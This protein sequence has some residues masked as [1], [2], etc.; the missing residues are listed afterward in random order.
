[1]ND[2]P[3]ALICDFGGVLTSPL[4]EAIAAYGAS[5]GISLGDVGEAMARMAQRD[6]GHPLFE[7]EKGRISEAD[8]VEALEVE[9]GSRLGPFGAYFDNLGRNERMIDYVRE[10]REREIRTALLTNNVR[11]WE[12]RWRAKLPEIED[13]FEVVVDSSSVGMRKPE[14]E[15]YELTVER[16][17]GGLLP[18]EC[19][20]VDD[21]DVN[22]ET[23]RRLGMRAVLFDDTERALAEIER[24]FG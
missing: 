17:G 23:A 19:V 10:L 4:V 6:G 3:R 24:A 8:F 21:T 13:L 22:C 5:S 2:R 14:P 11:E 9:L 16:L 1:M 12:P 7:L 20:F 18:P 15:I